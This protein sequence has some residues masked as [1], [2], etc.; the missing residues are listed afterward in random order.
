MQLIAVS[1]N[2]F[3]LHW[4]CLRKKQLLEPFTNVVIRIQIVKTANRDLTV[5]VFITTVRPIDS[6][7]ILA[8]YIFPF[9][10]ITIRCAVNRIHQYANNMIIDHFLSFSNIR[11]DY[12]RVK[13]ELAKSLPPSVLTETFATPILIT[14][15]GSLKDK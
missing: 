12:T 7:F 6:K 15:V 5:D 11:L 4:V 2:K 9:N 8:F 3:S 1:W 14:Y 10:T 13:M